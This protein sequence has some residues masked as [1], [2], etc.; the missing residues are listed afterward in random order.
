MCT[1]AGWRPTP[2]AAVPP[3]PRALP[4][5]ALDRGT[6]QTLEDALA[7][8]HAPS[9]FDSH[10][11]AAGSATYLLDGGLGA[12][13]IV[14]TGEPDWSAVLRD[15]GYTRLA[16][17]TADGL[18]S[19][20]AGAERGRH[21]VRFALGVHPWLVAERQTGWAERLRQGLARWPEACVGEIG[22]DRAR[23]DLCPWEEQKH[24]FDEQLHIA[25]SYR[26]P[27]IIHCVRADG[28]LLEA[29]IEAAGRDMLPPVLVLHAF[30][31]SSE[32]ADRLLRLSGTRV[33]FGFSAALA[34]RTKVRSVIAMVPADRLLLESDEHD[35][36]VAVVAVA[37]ACEYVAE[38]RGWS[39]EE[40]AQRTASNA[41]T[42]LVGPWEPDVVVEGTD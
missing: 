14:S 16:K 10:C 28:A 3:E 42:A 30:G 2:T 15:A 17:G 39:V 25:A 1:A 27:A 37:R 32:T 22:L 4:P 40:T 35:P 20:G 29:L 8:V 34:K 9:L 41:K 23:L 31:G 24:V 6:S 13:C 5:L 26:R 18:V 38:A 19:E 33:F 21:R 36:V 12:V 7:A 11:H